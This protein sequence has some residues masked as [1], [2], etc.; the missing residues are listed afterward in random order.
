MD[1]DRDVEVAYDVIAYPFKIISCSG[2]EMQ[3]GTLCRE[4]SCGCQTYTF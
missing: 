3:S 4:G 1:G 2:C